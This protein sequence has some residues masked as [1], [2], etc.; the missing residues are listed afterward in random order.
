M[1]GQE[2]DRQELDLQDSGRHQW[3]IPKK[4]LGKRQGGSTG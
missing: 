4:Q 2:G 3:V 1:V